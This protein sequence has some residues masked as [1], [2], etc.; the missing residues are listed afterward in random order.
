MRPSLLSRLLLTCFTLLLVLA[1]PS[2]AAGP[3][4]FNYTGDVQQWTVPAGVTQVTAVVSGGGGGGNCWG[5]GSGGPGAQVQAKFAVTPGETLD[6]AVGGQGSGG[7]DPTG[8]WSTSGHAGGDGGRGD[9]GP[10]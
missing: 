4:T 8:G 9:W 5:S 1:A 7:C 2:F 10:T 3:Y 6:V